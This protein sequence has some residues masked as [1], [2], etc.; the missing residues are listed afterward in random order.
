MVSNQLSYCSTGSHTIAESLIKPCMKD[1]VTSMITEEHAK[2][3]KCVPLSDKTISRL[4]K[5]MSNFCE[6]ELIRR[7]KISEHGF[8]IQ[9]DETTLSILD[10][11]FCSLL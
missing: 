6:N 2:L 11:R 7:L 5:D 8:T 4:V 3:I 9:I 10:Y 1:A